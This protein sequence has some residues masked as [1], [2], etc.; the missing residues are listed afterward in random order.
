MQFLSCRTFEY[1]HIVSTSSLCTLSSINRQQTKSCHPPK[2]AMVAY[3][4]WSFTKHSNSTTRNTSIAEPCEADAKGQKQEEMERSQQ[5]R[6][7]IQKTNKQTNKQKT[8]QNNDEKKKE[9]KEEKKMGNWFGIEP[10][11]SC[12]VRLIP[13][14]TLLRMTIY[15]PRKVFNLIPFS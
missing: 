9:R 6:E 1:F 13:T 14:T 8:K 11:T 15:I 4:R 12:L 5:G 3:R 2:A 10:R 7:N